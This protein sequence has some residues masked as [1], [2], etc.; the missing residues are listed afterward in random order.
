MKLVVFDEVNVGVCRYQTALLTLVGMH[1]KVCWR[2][3]M[4]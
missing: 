4:D 1:G 2:L 3:C